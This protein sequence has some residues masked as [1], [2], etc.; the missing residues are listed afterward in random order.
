MLTIAQTLREATI[1]LS[2]T[3]DTA[4]LDTEL[5]MAHTL[6]VSRSHM[7]LQNM[8]DTAPH[9]FAA[10]IDRRL[11]HEPIAHIIGRQEFYGLDLLVT[12][13]V[14]IPRGDSE[15]LIEAARE[16]FVGTPPRR[17]ADLGTGSGALLLAALSVFPQAMGIGIERSS[18]ARAIAADNADRLDMAERCAIVAGDW[19]I[20]GWSAQFG[21]FD[22]ILCNP[23]YVESTA[24]LS[25]SVREYEPH[26]ALFAGIDGLDDYRI[27]IPQLRELIRADGCAIVEIGATQADAVMD[28]ARLSTLEPVLHRDLAGRPRAMVLTVTAGTMG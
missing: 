21:L 3:S 14:L 2:E 5:L 4:R 1:R 11:A 19:S 26:Q 17:I 7:L 8:R 15:C 24:D 22:L 16:F 13:N 9:E 20:P 27:L 25:P 18:A 12:P 10:L 6:G 23:P 28:V